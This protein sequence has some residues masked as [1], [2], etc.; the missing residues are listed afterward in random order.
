[1]A[2]G[3]LGSPERQVRHV[4]T[5]WWARRVKRRLQVPQKTTDTPG[6]ERGREAPSGIKTSSSLS[7]ES[8]LSSF[9][10][11]LEPDAVAKRL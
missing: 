8:S 5:V 3:F 6:L 7:L 11:F 9:F 4:S 10:R 1:L 2:A